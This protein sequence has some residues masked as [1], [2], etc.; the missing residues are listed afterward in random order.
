MVEWQVL[1][2][3]QI[4]VAKLISDFSTYYDKEAI[5]PIF[6]HMQAIDGETVKYLFELGYKEMEE[7]G[8][9][10]DS[11]LMELFNAVMNCNKPIVSVGLM[12]FTPPCTFFNFSKVKGGYFKISVFWHKD[13][14]RRGTT[15]NLT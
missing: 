14:R 4:Q 15:P 8:D 3:W 12:L 13:P 9:N 2:I 5:I 11:A 1:K 10:N 7:S 6:T